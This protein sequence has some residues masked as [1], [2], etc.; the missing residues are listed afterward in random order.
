VIDANEF[1][2]K[3]CVGLV[4]KEKRVVR[5]RAP[6]AAFKIVGGAH[7]DIKVTRESQM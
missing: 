7:W 4:V 1:L 3:D 6:G 2:E 5:V